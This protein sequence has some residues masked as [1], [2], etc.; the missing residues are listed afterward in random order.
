LIGGWRIVHTLGHKI[1]ALNTMSG[2]CAESSAAI[3]I[4]AAT[5]WG[6]P[7][8]TTHTITG[9][10]TGAGLSKHYSLVHWE[11]IKRIIIAWFL[12]VPAAALISSLLMYFG[13][14]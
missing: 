7:V 6:I 4:F 13:S 1:T 2:A 8:S 5:E 3:T 9:S 14:R 12:T 10:I 11:V